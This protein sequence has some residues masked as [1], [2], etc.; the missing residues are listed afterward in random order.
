ML[1]IIVVSFNTRDLLRTCLASVMR[2]QPGAEI[3]V[4]DNASR[5]GSAGMV[6]LEFPGVKL[7]ESCTNLGFA[8]ANNAGIKLATG[9]YV[10]LLNSDAELGDDSLTRCVARL[11]QNPKLGAVHPALIGADGKAQ[12]CEY[13]LPSL[14]RIARDVVRLSAEPASAPDQT[15]LAGTAL[16]IRRT[17]LEAVGG[18]LDAGYFIY[19]EDADLSARLRAAG[20][21]LAV[22]PGTL[23]RHVGGASGGGPDAGR[24]ADLYAW[25]CYGKHRWFRRNRPAWEAAAVWLLDV[26][27]VPR[28]FLQGV[29]H[30]ARRK[31]AWAHARVTARILALGLLG[32]KPRTL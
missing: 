21:E 13:P 18:G 22:E 2:H 11:E 12:Q 10:A 20:W 8:G 27:D 5:D 31:A 15:W 23:V 3:I 29:R 26:M 28:K 32:L 17:A 6:R 1:S 9:S 19:W 24:R 7:V 14:R 25:Y 30:G 4:V 16:V